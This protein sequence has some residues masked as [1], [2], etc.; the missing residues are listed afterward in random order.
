MWKTAKVLDEVKDFNPMITLFEKDEIIT[1]K[2]A[3]NRMGTTAWEVVNHPYRNGFIFWKDS[4]EIL[5]DVF[6]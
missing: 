6:K 5:G 2:E 4:V 1:V 3:V